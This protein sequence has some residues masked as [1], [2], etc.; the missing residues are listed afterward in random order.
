MIFYAFGIPLAALLVLW[1]Y[2][3]I[4]VMVVIMTMNAGIG[5]QLSCFV[6]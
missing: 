3:N 1:E 4:Q 6:R 2:K 5:R